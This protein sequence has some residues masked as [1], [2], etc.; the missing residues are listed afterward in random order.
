MRGSYIDAMYGISG[1]LER[2]CN[3]DACY[4]LIDPSVL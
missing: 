1:L 3:H 4:F 2:C